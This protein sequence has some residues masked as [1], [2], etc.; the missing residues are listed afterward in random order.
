M[1]ITEGIS[2]WI[3]SRSRYIQCIAD[4][5]PAQSLK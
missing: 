5:R 2:T 4:V 3:A 1:K